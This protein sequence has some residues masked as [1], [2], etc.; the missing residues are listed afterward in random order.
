MTMRAGTKQSL[1]PF[2]RTPS[3]SGILQSLPVISTAKEHLSSAVKRS[4]KLSYA[5][6]LKNEAEKER[7]RAAR[8]VREEFEATTSYDSFH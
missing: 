4:T 6:G 3:T 5:A 8:Q 1:P 7:N 2:S